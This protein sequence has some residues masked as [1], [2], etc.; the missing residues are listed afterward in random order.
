M[1]H[2]HIQS[3]IER[4]V[5]AIF[6]PS[7]IYE[8]IENS[9]ATNHYNCQC[10]K[11]SEVIEK[12]WIQS[13][14]VRSSISRHLSTL[15]TINLLSNHFVKSFRHTVMTLQLMILKAV[16]HGYQVL[17]DFKKDLQDKADELL[18][19]LVLKRRKQLCFLD[20]H[21]TSTQKS[22]MGLLTSS[23]KKVSTF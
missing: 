23:P 18:S 11:L 20:A 16:E 15:L 1:V 13:P 12:T 5:D 21:I 19:K 17:A 10:S 4:K 8:Q 6:Y 14:T 3:L 22:T 9:Q 7:V 2:G